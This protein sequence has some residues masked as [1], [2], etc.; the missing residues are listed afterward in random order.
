MRLLDRVIHS[1]PRAFDLVLA[2]AFDHRRRTRVYL[3][4]IRSNTLHLMILMAS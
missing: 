4:R 3:S 1:Y 2:D